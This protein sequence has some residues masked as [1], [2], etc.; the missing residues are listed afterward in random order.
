MGA[1]KA[2]D[3]GNDAD[4]GHGGQH[5]H[6]SSKE[7]RAEQLIGEALLEDDPQADAKDNQAADLKGEWIN[8]ILEIVL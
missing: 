3:A 8:I 4:E 7:I 2:H 5:V 1:K 6:G